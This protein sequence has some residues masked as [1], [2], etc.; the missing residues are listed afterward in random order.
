MANRSEERR[1]KTDSE[2]N[3][4]EQAN[5]DSGKK[6]KQANEKNAARFHHGAT[7]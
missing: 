7:V 3:K 5:R 6:L 4:S 2:L 1:M